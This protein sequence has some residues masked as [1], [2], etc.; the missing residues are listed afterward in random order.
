[1][2]KTTYSNARA[3][4]AGLC[5]EVT[6]NNEVVIIQRRK[7]GSV[8]MVAADELE[9]LVETAHLLRSPKNAQRLMS[10]LQRALKKQ[11]R[12]SDVKNLRKEI[13]IE[14]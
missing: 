8:A 10:A 13:G 1:M 14:G 3:N 6:E 11:G 5:N 7:G 2:V 9:S 12:P 4:L